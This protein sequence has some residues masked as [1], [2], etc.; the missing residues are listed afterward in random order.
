ME[1][2]SAPISA[3]PTTAGRDDALEKLVREHHASVTRLAYRLL[4]W[5]GDVEDLVHDVFLTAFGK[6]DRFRNESSTWTW[7]AA[8]TI[9]RCRSQRRRA[10]LHLK[11]LSRRDVVCE[12]ARGGG[13][14]EQDETAKRVRKAVAKLSARDRELIV[15]HYL[16][17]LSIPEIC[18]LL[19][20]KDKT[21]HVRLHRARQRLKG[22]LGDE[23]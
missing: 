22:L 7:L 23:R 6:L 16:E 12:T 2:K 4:G 8:I 14:L 21:I 13:S 20:E 5:R 15:L 3:L 9:N 18:K 17:E 19:G 1:L 11:W 10:L